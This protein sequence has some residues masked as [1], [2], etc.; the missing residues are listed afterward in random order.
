MACNDDILLH[1]FMRI[2]NFVKESVIGRQ[3]YKARKYTL[4]IG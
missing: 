4:S 1:A 3:D 2:P